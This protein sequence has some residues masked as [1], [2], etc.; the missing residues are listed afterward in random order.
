MVDIINYISYKIWKG[1]KIV[2]KTKIYDTYSG[3]K[4]DFIPI[5]ENEVSIYVCGPTVYNDPHV[6]NFRPAVFFDLVQ[7]YFKEIGYEVRLVS[8]YT[9]IDDKI[10]EAAKKRNI[11]EKE[12]SDFYIKAY[13]ANFPELNLGQIYQRPRVSDHIEDIERFIQAALDEKAAYKS[14]DDIYFDV[15][16]I[17]DYGSLSKMKIDDLVSGSRIEVDSK[18]HSPLDFVLWKKTVD[19][20]VKY[21]APFGDGRPG[22]H[23]EC[24]VMV[25]EIFKRPLV[26]IH[27]GGF[28]LKFPHHEN[29]RA[30]ALA[31]Y[32][33]K[34]ANYWM[35]VGFVSLDGEKMSKSLGN[36]ITMKDFLKEHGGDLYRLLVLKNHYRSP[37]SFSDSAIKST[38]D[39]LHKYEAAKKAASLRLAITKERPEGLLKEY[40]EPFLL[41]LADDFNVANALV[42][43]D[44]LTK[45]LNLTLRGQK[46]D[47]PIK[48]LL[49]TFNRLHD[50]LG[51][52]I[53]TP[54]LSAET[55]EIY[56]E[57]EDA[58]KNRNFQKSDELR[59]ELTRRGI[60]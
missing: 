23:T 41:A 53:S 19:D 11:S 26:D 45:D 47:H 36:I 10:I 55:I 39:E 37:L 17:A 20:G 30:Q 28:D 34:L 16:K 58:R 14:G 22:W 13:E 54:Q 31:V 35:H 50:I 49:F 24:I 52:Q 42:E 12:L 1:V 51:L 56:K 27:G 44:R 3:K 60:L 33:S 6:G 7:R 4:L 5:K 57:Y 32:H 40:Y 25:N 38:E 2:I 8:N 46:K 15:G 9:D 59:G 21:H 18:K 48:S 29:E 43:F